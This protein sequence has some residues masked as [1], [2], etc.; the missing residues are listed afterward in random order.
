MRPHFWLGY[1]ALIAACAHVALTT[2]AMGGTNATGIWLATFALIGIGAQAFLGTNLQSP[3]AYRVPLRRWHVVVFFATFALAFAHVALNA[4][5]LPQS[6]SSV[7]AF[8]EI[9]DGRR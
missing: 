6:V 2:G 8:K 7:T 3:G 9:A 4:A 1:L 5:F